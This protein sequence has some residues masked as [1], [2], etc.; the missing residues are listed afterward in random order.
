M[1]CRGA[2][3]FYGEG[4]AVEGCV[5]AFQGD[6]ERL[7]SVEEYEMEIQRTGRYHEQKGKV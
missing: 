4:F 1:G 5:F 2:R 6:L 7:R 3:F